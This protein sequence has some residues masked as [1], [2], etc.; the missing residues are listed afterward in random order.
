ME[1]W[2]H[3]TAGI[4]DM[5]LCK[6]PVSAPEKE[7]LPHWWRTKRWAAAAKTS[8]TGCSPLQE[9]ALSSI[10]LPLIW[11]LFHGT[12]AFFGRQTRRKEKKTRAYSQ[13]GFRWGLHTLIFASFSA[14][15]QPYIV[16]GQRTKETFFCSHPAIVKQI[17]LSEWI[18]SEA[19]TMR[20]I[21]YYIFT[22][23]G[24][25]AETAFAVRATSTRW[26]H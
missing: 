18:M 10:S 14:P 17:H 7:T 20:K 12:I 22:N 11:C 13:S 25:V 23:C 5:C 21:A 1:S 19:R 6:Q 8:P 2:L 16:R 3:L 24:F 9:S 15:P 26:R 4:A